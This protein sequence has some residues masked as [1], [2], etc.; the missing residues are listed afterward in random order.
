MPGNARI[1]TG[2][3]GV[4]GSNPAIPT[5]F[6]T[7]LGPFGTRAFLIRRSG[8]HSAPP[9]CDGPVIR[10][11]VALGRERAV[12]C[13]LPQVVDRDA[14]VGHPGQSGVAEVVPSYVVVA[15]GGDYLVPVGG[16][17]VD[18]RGDPP[19][20]GSGEQACHRVVADGVQ[21]PVHEAGSRG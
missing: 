11:Q 5:I 3:Q 20:A 19:S 21:S 7:A 9:R 8:R 12:A 16:V 4:A 14:G 18:G 2:G 10:V 17:A 13:D 15:Q 1:V 6:R